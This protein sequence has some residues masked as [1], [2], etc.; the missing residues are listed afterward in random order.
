[1]NQGIE[2]TSGCR[3]GCCRS[4]CKEMVPLINQFQKELRVSLVVRFRTEL[5][6]KSDKKGRNN[7]RENIL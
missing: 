6:E 1:M 4:C 2:Q 5:E 7:V 3:R